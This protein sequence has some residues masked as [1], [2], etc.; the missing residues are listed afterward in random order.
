MA[1]LFDDC[2]CSSRVSIGSDCNAQPRSSSA[3]L[4]ENSA[5][6][7]GARDS[8]A[9]KWDGKRVPG[10]AAAMGDKLMARDPGLLESIWEVPVSPRETEV[11]PSKSAA[12]FFWTGPLFLL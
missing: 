12:R 7:V 9:S 6:R 4:V 3:A 8:A 1:R 10:S 11:D 2:K 5:D